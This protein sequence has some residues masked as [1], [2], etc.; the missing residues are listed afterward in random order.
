MDAW[1]SAGYV[2][3]RHPRKE[4]LMSV[5]V[6]AVAPGFNAETYEAVTGKAMPGDQLPDGCELHIAGPVEQGWRVITVWESPEAFDR[7]RE[8][9]LLPALPDVA[10]EEVP[11]P[12]EPEVNPVH[13]LITS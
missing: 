9:K 8:E 5:V 3:L 4:I 12:L 10:G 2:P 13:R 6:S 7:F 11:P 1:T